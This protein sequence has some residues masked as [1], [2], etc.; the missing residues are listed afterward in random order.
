M[1]QARRQT[2]KSAAK[3]EVRGAE[4]QEQS[5]VGYAAVFY[6][7]SD[8]NTEYWL[9]EDYVERIMPG[10]FDRALSEGH[11]ARGLFDHASQMLLGRVANGTCRLSVDDVGLRF[12][13]PINS[14]DSDHCNTAAKIRRGDVSGCSFAFSDSSATW[15]EFESNGQMVYVRNLT[16]LYLHDVGPVTYP[17]YGATEVGLRTAVASK[18]ELVEARSTLAVHRGEIENRQLADEID[19]KAIEARL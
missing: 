6:R 11:D 13:I 8:A 2:R 9:G 7:A 1:S 18:D 3:V 12:E 15:E 14:E 16:D 10:C 5:I 4:G 19:I 17:A